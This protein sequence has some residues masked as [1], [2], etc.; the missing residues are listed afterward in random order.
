[1]TDKKIIKLRNQIWLCL[2]GS[3]F[4]I[5]AFA[6]VTAYLSNVSFSHQRFQSIMQRLAPRELQMILTGDSSTG[7]GFVVEVD[8]QGVLSIQGDTD[9]SLMEAE[10]LVNQAFSQYDNNRIRNRF[11]WRFPQPFLEYQGTYWSYVSINFAPDNLTTHLV[12]WDASE[13]RLEIANF[14]FIFAMAGSLL[15]IL[16]GAMS[17]VAANLLV[18]PAAISLE[19][20]KQFVAD[21][22]HELK[23][24]LTMVKNNLTALQMSKD[25]TTDNQKRWLNNIDFGYHRMQHLI[26]DLLQ[27]AKLEENHVSEQVLT[28]FDISQIAT[29]V[30]EQMQQQA[31][32]K[33]IEFSLF[34][35][36]D[37]YVTA[38]AEKIM[39][40]MT[41]LLDNAIKYANQNGAVIVRVRAK[42]NRQLAS[43]SVENSGAG[44]PAEKLPKIFERFYQVDESRNSEQKSH[45]LGL[46]IA[47][48]IVEKAGG[49]IEVSSAKNE[50]TT[51]YFTIKTS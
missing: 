15:F 12:F 8:N 28:R 35:D 44:I 16:I 6:L 48:T 18:K 47:K 43:F 33:Q 34:I 39:Q 2:W 14:N 20:Q 17:H 36:S 9:F 38:N 31:T 10:E 19:R 42:Q 27:L 21:V 13:V 3:F 50:M 45:G 51:A 24:P 40:V 23:T 11:L 25:E 22:S 49:K 26:T 30:C 32:D 7:T 46:S 37:I 41:I 29:L 4:A 1:M 5:V